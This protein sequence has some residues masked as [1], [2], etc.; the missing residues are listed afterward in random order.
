MQNPVMDKDT[1]A[2]DAAN[3]LGIHRRELHIFAFNVTEG[4]EPD[5]EAIEAILGK[6]GYDIN[7]WGWDNDGP[8]FPNNWVEYNEEGKWGILM[9]DGRDWEKNAKDWYQEV[10]SKILNHK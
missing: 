3:R 2:Q 5:R 7:D 6:M 4:E 1:Q 10:K 8:P 9:A